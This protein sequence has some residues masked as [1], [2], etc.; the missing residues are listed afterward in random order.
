MGRYHFTTTQQSRLNNWTESIRMMIPRIL[1]SCVLLSIS[2]TTSTPLQVASIKEGPPRE[3]MVSKGSNVTLPCIAVGYP[4]PDIT[5]TVNGAVITNGDK[6]RIADDYLTINE[7][8]EE[9]EG[10]YTCRATNHGEDSAEVTMIVRA[11]TSIIAGPDDRTESVFSSLIFPCKVVTDI[12][13]GNL[14]VTW[15]KDNVSIDNNWDEKVYQDKEDSLVLNN[16]SFTDSGVYTCEGSNSLTTDIASGV[17]TVVG[18]RPELGLPRQIG[19]Q[20]AGTDVSL[21]C[22]VVGGWPTPEVLWYKDGQIVDKKKVTIEED[23]T[24][25]IRNAE[26]EDTG[27]YTCTA[28]NSEGSDNLTTQLNIRRR[29]T[30]ISQAKQEEFVEGSEVTF[31]CEYEVDSGLLGGLTVSWFK[32]GEY[33]DIIQAPELA[34][35]LGESLITRPDPVS[36]CL[37]Y[38]PGEDPRLYMLANSSLRICSLSQ[39]DIGKYYCVINTDL[40]Q[41]VTSQPSYLYSATSPL[42]WIIISIIIGILLPLTIIFLVCIYSMNLEEGGNTDKSDIYYTTEG[43]ENSIEAEEDKSNEVTKEQGNTPGINPIIIEHFDNINLSDGQNYFL[44]D[45][46]FEEASDKEKYEV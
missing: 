3:M 14:S 16:I 2:V 36:P 13:V 21:V 35:V 44:L 32:D 15:M 43:D 31:D 19:D 42:L 38:K 39:S 8:S 17:L 5:W 23:N 18:V 10:D 11:I 29:S 6:Y 27:I 33:L 1:V 40:D 28:E 24:L 22:E 7:V 41:S 9:D 4:A 25:K 46:D 30:I 45:E 20:L 12:T 34:P 37:T 26:K